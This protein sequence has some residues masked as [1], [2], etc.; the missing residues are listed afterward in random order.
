MSIGS[1][2]PHPLIKYAN[3]LS[4]YRIN[5]YVISLTFLFFNKHFV[6][7]LSGG[8]L[9]TWGDNTN[10]QLEDGTNTSN[11][12]PQLIGNGYS[13]IAAGSKHMLA[14]KNNDLY[15]WGYNYKGQL[16]LNSTVDQNTPGSMYQVMLQ[17]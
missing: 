1:I 13:D 8:N 3:I 15:S 9:Y 2:I 14:V 16:G 12:T 17:R 6:V 11:S 4:I 5:T 10:G 7:E